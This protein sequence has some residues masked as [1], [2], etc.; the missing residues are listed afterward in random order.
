MIDEDIIDFVIKRLELQGASYVEARLEETTK[1][2]FI[3]K[4]GNLDGTFFEEMSGIGV[5]YLIDNALGFIATNNLDKTNLNEKIKKSVN[6][7]KSAGK[8]NE[9]INLT[10]EK[11]VKKE[12]SVDEKIKLF[13]MDLSE[14]IKGV[15]EIDKELRDPN[16]SLKER[17][18]SYHDAKTT[19]HLITNEGVNIKATVP[20]LNLFYILSTQC[21][22]KST[23]RMWDYGNTGGFE[24]FEKWNLSE[25]LKNE[26]GKLRDSL[27]YGKETPVGCMDVIVAPEVTGIM[28]HESAGHPYEADRIFGREAAQAG[29]SFINE[30]MIGQEIGNE[31]VNVVDDSTIPNTNGFFLYDN[32]GVES[33]RKYLIKSG[34]INEFL[35]NRATAS[36]MG[37]EK[38]NGSS[39][40][41]QYDLETIVRM[42]NTFLLPGDCSEEELIEEVKKGIYLKNFMEWNIDDK[43]LNQRYVGAEAY[44]I[45]DGKLTSQIV[46]PSIEITTPQL[47]KSVENIANNTELHSGTC[48]KGEPMQGIP[49]TFGG[50][51]M[52]LKN[53]SVKR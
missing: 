50:P 1:S 46:N 28:V 39:R 45:E 52:K 5:R 31:I 16:L 2:G 38:S 24:F 10:S 35:H 21:G 49:V 42:S 12:Y 22:H 23:Q 44:L 29:E 53:I 40:A 30:K 34:K 51:S 36:E 9:K 7:V 26:A 43:R 48:G 41:T 6:T 32:E 37:L 4:N 18:L 33:Q 25:V 47:W 15:N 3:L 19:E 14:K 20:R 11:A 17:Y 13:D 27:D 8:L